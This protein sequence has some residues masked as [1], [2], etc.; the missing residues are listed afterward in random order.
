MHPCTDSSV[1]QTIQVSHPPPNAPIHNAPHDITAPAVD[2]QLAR[3][4]EVPSPQVGVV[5]G[6]NKAERKGTQTDRP[7]RE[8]GRQGG[9]Q[10]GKQQRDRVV[11]YHLVMSIIII[12]IKR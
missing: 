4:L 12:I 10:A 8:A 2:R 5:W 9:S 6:T 3:P 11:D 1:R 7:G